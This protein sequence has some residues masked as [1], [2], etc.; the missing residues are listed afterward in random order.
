MREREGGRER[1]SESE[2]E[3]GREGEIETTCK[4]TRQLHIY[5]HSITFF[6]NEGYTISDRK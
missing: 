5:I 4:S 1:E 3:G 2:R 6:P